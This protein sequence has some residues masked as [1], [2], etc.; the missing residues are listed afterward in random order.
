MS[1][2]QIVTNRLVAL[3]ATLIGCGYVW[4]A[5]GET[6][7]PEKLKEFINDFGAK[8]YKFE[9]SQ[10]VVDAAHWLGKQ[11][12]DCSGM[13]LWCLQQLG[14]IPKDQDYNAE[15]FFTQLCTPIGYRELQPGDLLFRR[16]A[17]GEIVHIAIYAGD[18]KTIEAMGTRYGVVI[19]DGSSNSF[20]L[21]GRLKFAV[22][23][24]ANT[25]EKPLGIGRIK[26]TTLNIRSGPSGDATD[27]GDLKAGDDVNI[28]ETRSGWYRIGF[29]SWICADYVTFTATATTVVK[30]DIE[31]LVDRLVACDGIVT[32]KAHWVNVLQGKEPAKPEYLVIAF[33]RALNM[34]DKLKGVK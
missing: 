27:I 4:G 19:G 17:S 23:D 12:F 14:F 31:K 15:M 16:S 26:A 7:T 29:N 6:L 24:D 21:F 13:I 5:Q 30:S 9:D 32:D 18:G 33:G 20:N 8:F 22:G 3:A 25:Q 10:G 28:F 34:I 2:L 1:V 11:C